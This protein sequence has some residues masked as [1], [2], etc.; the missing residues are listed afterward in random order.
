MIGLPDSRYGEEVIVCTTPPRR[1]P[2]HRTGRAFRH[3][4]IAD[5]KIPRY[6]HFV[7]SFPMTIKGKIQKFVVRDHAFE[8]LGVHEVSSMPTA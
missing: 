6:V 2:R 7:D 5:Y 4:Q 8:L 3:G 1:N